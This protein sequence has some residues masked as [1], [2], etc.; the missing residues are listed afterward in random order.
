M[1]RWGQQGRPR[2]V[3]PVIMSQLAAHAQVAAT[4]HA[5]EAASTV[6]GAGVAALQAMLRRGAPPPTRVVALLQTYPRDRDAM[7]T[8]L[9]QRL[10]NQ[11]VQQ[12]TATWQGTYVSE[13]STEA[14]IG[15]APA[16]LGDYGPLGAYGPLGTLGPVGD[17][18]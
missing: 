8:M 13:S 2:C 7:L 18:V 9:H 16:E 4:P 12:V 6:S 15:P 3:V 5:S 17:N 10:G 14:A 1:S 11:Y